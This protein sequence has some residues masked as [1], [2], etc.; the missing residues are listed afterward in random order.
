M[1]KLI[2][3]T[4]L[5]KTF[6]F[7]T[8][9][10]L[11]VQ[12]GYH[13]WP[14][15][16]MV[17]G[18]RVDYL[19]PTLYLTDLFVL[20][21]L[22]SW[23]V[24][25]WKTRKPLKPTPLFIVGILVILANTIFSKNIPVSM[26]QW[27]KVIEFILFG[28][29][30]AKTKPTFHFIIP[31]FSIAILYSSVIALAQFFLQRHIGGPFWLLGERTFFADTSGIAQI[32]ICSIVNHSCR[33]LLRPYGTFPHPNVLAGFL[34]LTLPF[35][36]W[37]FL[38]FK[39]TD[40]WFM[41]IMLPL[42][43]VL[44]VC[45]LVVTFGRSAW[46][47]GTLGILFVVHNTMRSTKSHFYIKY[48][49]V[50]YVCAIP[51]AIAGAYYFYVTLAGSESVIVRNELN[52]AALTMIS[53]N[54]FLGVGWGNFLTILPSYLTTRA[55]YFLQPVHNIYLL[56][57]SQF[58]FVGLIFFVVCIISVSKR[59]KKISPIAGV[60][61]FLIALLGLVDHYFL[62]LQQ[63]QLLFSIIAGLC[64]ASSETRDR[65]PA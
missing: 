45:A 60:L 64:V 61:L 58:G 29:Y 35:L 15:W 19:S 47:A 59:M 51:C 52:S 49:K 37:F 2:L 27:M 6:F 41:R 5:H 12:L 55:I 48:R 10:L 4:P 24:E 9:L 30:I 7:L 39:K 46:I 65:L 26:Y 63:G 54:A 50:M 1:K 44:G 38:G 56:M 21:T 8:L 13:F 31:A 33:L 18:R 25:G 16:A 34:A 22:A 23:C 36:F 14:S 17:L 43:F 3:T 40:P 57:I 28:Y 42:S 62:T 11:P 32:N 53:D 20:A